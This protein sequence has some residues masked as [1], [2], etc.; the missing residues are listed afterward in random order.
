VPTV[1]LFFRLQLTVFMLTAA[2]L[3]AFGW[4]EVIRERDL[5][6]SDTMGDNRT[7]AHWLSLSASRIWSEVGPEAAER[8]VADASRESVGAHAAVRPLPAGVAANPGVVAS[9]ESDAQ[10]AESVVVRT[11]LLVGEKPVAMLEVVES[12]A[13]RDAYIRRS[14]WRQLWLGGGLLASA[15]LVSAVL[16][17]SLV[18]RPV[19]AIVR[20]ARAAGEGD[21]STR[22]AP[23]GANE[24]AQVGRA[25]DAMCERIEAAQS[26]ERQA[27][28]A[29][30]LAMEQLRHAERLAMVG[31]LSAGLAHELGTP[32]NVIQIRAGSIARGEESGPDAITSATVIGEQAARL[33]RIVRDLLD[34]ARPRP[35]NRLPADLVGLTRRAA[36]LIRPIARS[37][38]VVLG[39]PR[40]RDPLVIAPV[41][42]AQI[43]Q[44]VSNLLMNAV[45]A[46]YPAGVTPDVRITVDVAMAD[47]VRS[48]TERRYARICVSDNG[49]GIPPEL[50]ARVFEPFVTTK[51][52]GQ[53][54]GMGLTVSE[55]LVRE[56]GGWI[57]AESR[58]G[59]GTRF[60]VFLPI[61]HG[62]ASESQR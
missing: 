24:L 12:M 40:A 48:G 49:R 3:M 54:T 38:G 7:I 53:G 14:I 29:Q 31:A 16:G 11:N 25:V 36:D 19:E 9:V 13:A 42:A 32:L 47:P 56:H 52:A 58:V 4:S 50:L 34:F 59:Q 20:R 37:T 55:G 43:E 23:T 28:R 41:D 45:Q 60:T 44:V 22:L 33:G 51:P 15:M 10:G 35:P 26:G 30:L 8:F 5:F 57:L 18:G 27:T 46:G 21:L 2:L 62:E 39:E 6:V 61:D 17:Y 1:R